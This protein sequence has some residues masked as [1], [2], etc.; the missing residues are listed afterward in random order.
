MSLRDLRVVCGGCQF[1]WLCPP[2]EA[3]AKAVLDLDTD[4][5][6]ELAPLIDRLERGTLRTSRDGHRFKMVEDEPWLFEL[7]LNTTKPRLRLYFVEQGGVEGARA[8]GLLLIPKPT[9]TVDQQR[10]RQNRDARV[11]YRRFTASRGEGTVT[12]GD[13]AAT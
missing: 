1:A 3:E 2:V 10:Q 6:Y 13:A 11:A 5:R 4:A 12:P 7:T 9:G 8:T